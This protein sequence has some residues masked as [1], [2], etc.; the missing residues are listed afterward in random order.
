MKKKTISFMKM[1]GAGNDFVI[2]DDP[3]IRGLA[4]LAKKICD[5][6]TGIGADGLICLGTS[7]KAQYRMRIFNADGS[8][9]EMCGNGVRCLAAFI[10]RKRRISKNK[11]FTIETMAGIIEA[12]V[13][14]E[15]ANV[16]LS[17]PAG[18]AASI[19]IKFNRRTLHAA[20]MD[21]GVP[22]A[23]VFVDQL[24]AIRVKDIGARI[25][26]HKKFQPKGANVNFV[27]QLQKD[28]IAVRTYERGVEDETKACGTGSV[29]S[30]I[31]TYL[32]AN[33]D[34]K[35]KSSAS[36]RVKT[37][38]GEKLKIAFDLRDGVV[39]NVWLKGSAKFIA[40]GQYYV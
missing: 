31:I 10:A 39:T 3:K 25:R 6:T 35:Q 40:Q 18:Y 2:L 7:R 37:Q 16:R 36:M 19:P 13:D 27:E 14:G 17:D 8:E 11:R 5:R 4:S 21:T 33:P 26:F 30:G 34:V 20:F 29:A 15:T 24:D 1:T 23:I 12:E 32:K 22:H 28:L 9:A 38:S